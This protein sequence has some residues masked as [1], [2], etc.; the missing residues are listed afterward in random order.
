MIYLDN[1][2][3]TRIDPRVLEAMM[4]YLTDEYGNAGTLYGLGRKS[5]EA[6]A[7]ARQQV[8]DLIGAKPEQIIFTSGGSEANN[9]VFAGV[10][11]YLLSVGK[12]HIVTT[13]IEH[14]SVLNAVENLCKAQDIVGDSCIKPRF[15]VTYIKPRRNSSIYYE[16]V[17]KVIEREPCTG[18]VSIMHTNNETGLENYWLDYIAEACNQRGILF[19]TDCVQAAGCNELN[20]DEIGCDFMSLSSHK[21]HGVKGVG[22]LYARD[23]SVMSPIIFGGKSQE[24][25]LR[26]GTE[27]VAGIV[28]FGAAC[29]ILRLNQKKDIKY[30][31]E[32]LQLLYDSIQKHLA[33]YGLEH[34]SHVNGGTGASEHSKAINMRFDNV[35]GETLL[36]MLDARDVCVSAG[37][38]CRSHESE[39]SRVLLAMGIDADD[40]RNSIRLS[41]S[42]MNSKE[43]IQEAAKIIADCVCVLYQPS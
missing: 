26:G 8:A 41:L 21:I 11:D 28:G 36:L 31:A 43:E 20:V 5:S 12:T 35:D 19:H 24:F 33:E 30:I 2:S 13:A 29:E 1:A 25:G 17:K 34:I 6:I 27:N 9:M 38:A 10:K 15:D 18:I 42:R 16:D 40:A 14:D 4:P 23:K 32:L 37:S 7:K 39:P 3:T 22:A